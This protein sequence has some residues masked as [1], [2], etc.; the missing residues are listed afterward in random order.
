MV[1]LP[2]RAKHRFRAS[3]NRRIRRSMTGRQREN[4]GCMRSIDGYRAQLHI[5]NGNAIAFSR[6]GND[7]SDTFNP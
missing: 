5:N 2:V 6:R 4:S 7:W 1:V 3:S